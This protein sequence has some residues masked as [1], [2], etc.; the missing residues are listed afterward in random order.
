MRREGA[1]RRRG[2]GRLCAAKTSTHLQHH[3]EVLKGQP[4]VP[5][6]QHP[7]LR[8]QGRSRRL[9]QQCKLSPTGA[10][11]AHSVCVWGGGGAVEWEECV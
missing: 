9:M 11:P 1:G 6:K 7:P 10:E 8:M 5:Y 3:R 4:R 2:E